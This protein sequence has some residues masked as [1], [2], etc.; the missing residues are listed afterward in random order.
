MRLLFL[1]MTIFLAL[2]FPAPVDLVSMSSENYQLLGDVISVGGDLT[3]STNYQ[4]FNT[5]GEAS[6]I[7]PTTST[8]VN[9]IVSAGFQAMAT[10]TYLTATLS[11]NAVS[12]GTLSKSA[13]ASA[14]QTLTVSTNAPTG[15]TATILEG[16]NLISG[17]NDINDVADG[18]IT[19]GSEEYGIRTSGAAGQMNNADTA[20]TAAAQT[21]A[22]SSTAAV[23]EQTTITYK[24][25]V[26]NTTAYGTYS[27]T[28]TITTTVNY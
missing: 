13:V 24:V 11:T 27:Q 5:L 20:I 9:Y 18:A 6:G 22:A 25:S 8:S 3:T 10:T 12:L 26:S 17:G 7:H 2:A 23:A 15:Y 28:T 1:V 14:S 16:G 19:A 21:I 4:V